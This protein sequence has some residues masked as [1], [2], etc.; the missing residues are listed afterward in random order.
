MFVSRTLTC[1]EQKLGVLSRLIA[2][3]AWAVRKLL[4]YT[5][6]AE[7]VLVVLPDA[8]S[9]LVTMDVHTHLQLRMHVVELQQYA[10]RWT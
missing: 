3:V 2:V 6:F 8:E 4:C 5:T 9:V 1:T 7:E 10:V